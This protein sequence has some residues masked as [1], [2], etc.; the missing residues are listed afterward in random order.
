MAGIEL[1]PPVTTLQAEPSEPVA[2]GEAPSFWTV[3]FTCDDSTGGVGGS[4]CL[5]TEYT[6]DALSSSPT[7]TPYTVPIRLDQPGTH[8]IRYR[9]I[10]LLGNVE[11]TRSTQLVVAGQDTTPPL[12]LVSLTANGATTPF[13]RK[14]MGSWTIALD[15]CTDEDLRPPGQAASGCA[16]T[17]YRID[18]SSFE[19][20]VDPVVVA[21]PGSHVFAYHSIDVAGNVEEIRSIDL[22]V[23]APADADGDG[24]LDLADNCIYAANPDQRDTNRNGWGNRCDADFNQNGTVDSN[25]GSLL[26]ARL[27]ST[28][29]DQD[30]DG[31][32]F[33]DAEDMNILKSSFR[34]PPGPNGVDVY[35]F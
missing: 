16:R 24:L 8:T 5:R 22:T 28:A 30:L 6:F 14:V 21:D 11:P 1:V 20:F 15:R 27:G 2:D 9:S 33:V 23:L 12:T 32:G 25:D 18:D 29:A 35:G 19:P 26:K 10:D 17:E 31:N 13:G 3:T 4:A 34:R 7:F